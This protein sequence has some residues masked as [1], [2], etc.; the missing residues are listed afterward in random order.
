[1]RRELRTHELCGV[2]VQREGP[3]PGAQYLDL[4]EL[5][6]GFQC[7]MHV[8]GP[9]DS[10]GPVSLR[11]SW[12][13]VEQV[14]DDYEFL[15]TDAV[16]ASTLKWMRERAQEMRAGLPFNLGEDWEPRGSGG[17]SAPG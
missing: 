12:V 9:R 3:L 4:G 10:G 1:M 7:L 16:P 15:C 11:A 13:A 17:G 6:A 5:L 8:Q 2:Y 14:L